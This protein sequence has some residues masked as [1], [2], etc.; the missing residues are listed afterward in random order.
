MID[1]RAYS[2]KVRRSLLKRDLMAGVPMMGLVFLLIL[3][4][5]FI[6]VLNMYFMVAP[7]IILYIVMRILTNKDPWMIDMLIDN[8]QQKDI[9]LP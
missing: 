3:A 8:I 1:M 6:Y 2:I 5:V 7:I 4:V 9:F